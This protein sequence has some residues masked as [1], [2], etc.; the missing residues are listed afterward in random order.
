LLE[1]CIR[2]AAIALVGVGAL[3]CAEPDPCTLESSSTLTVY[4]NN[5]GIFPDYVVAQYSESLK[6]RKAKLV[7]DEEERAALY[8]EAVLAF[9]GDPD[10]VLLQEIWS[11]KARDV[12]IAEL[13][14]AYP[15]VAHPEGGDFQPSGLVVFSKLPLTAFRFAE[16]TDG[17]GIDK[18]SKK[19]IVGVRLEKDGRDVAA[20]VTHLQ[21]GGEDQQIRPSQLRECDAM[22]ESFTSFNPDAVT[23]LAGDL[24]TASNK[25]SYQQIFENLSGPR[26]SHAAGCGTLEKTG[27]YDDDPTKRIDYLLSFGGV[28]AVSTVVDP[29]GET[30]ADHLAV[31]GTVTLD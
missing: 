17:E 12:L 5:V 1:G 20:F 31:F 26:D 28:D 14:D 18:L 13:A 30:L 11:G 22:I 16:F 8:A 7:A 24:N 29:G 10:L 9:D 4:S 15:H 2:A 25:P 23:I 19:G 3:A 27:R 21:A 6:A